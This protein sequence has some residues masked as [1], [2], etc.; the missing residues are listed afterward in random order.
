[1]RQ[2]ASLFRFR[3]AATLGLNRRAIEQGSENVSDVVQH[4]SSFKSRCVGDARLCVGR[5][6]E[7]QEDA[8]FHVQCAKKTLTS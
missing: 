4:C 2:A 8:C 5:Q 6:T 1:M 3:A 7:K